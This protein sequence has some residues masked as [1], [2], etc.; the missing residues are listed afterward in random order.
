MGQKNNSGK[1]AF[2]YILSGT[3][4]T[5][6]HDCT[7][8][9]LQLTKYC[10]ACQ[11]RPSFRGHCMPSTISYS[12]IVSYTAHS[13]SYCHVMARENFH[14]LVMTTPSRVTVGVTADVTA[15]VTAESLTSESRSVPRGFLRLHSGNQWKPLKIILS[16]MSRYLMPSFRVSNLRFPSFQTQKPPETRKR[17]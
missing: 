5:I 15:D 12:L 6:T 1:N 11:V 10:T 16:S 2:L 7:T 3:L 8:R 17:L 9:L 14:I 13:H 4:R